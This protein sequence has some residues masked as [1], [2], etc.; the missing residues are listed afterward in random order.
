MGLV[1]PL[2]GMAIQAGAAELP[3]LGEE[4]MSLADELASG[5]YSR[6]NLM[7]YTLFQETEESTLNPDNAAE[8][9]RYQ[10]V[11]N[12]R[13][14]LNL[15][16]RNWEF[17][18][19]P[20]F[21]AIWEKWEDGPR[22]GDDH[23]SS[24]LFLTEGWVRYRPIDELTL[25]F[26]RENL[27]WGPSVILSLSNPF[28]RDNGRNNP[29][30]EVPGLDYYRAIWIP[31]EAWTVS[32]IA[33]YGPGRSD[34]IDSLTSGQPRFSDGR[35]S[36]EDEF[37]KIYAL[38]LDYTGS[39]GYASIIHS[40]RE[41]DQ[42]QTGFFAGW[43]ASDALL[44]Y[45]EGNVEHEGKSGYQ[46]GASYT[47]EIGPTVNIEYLRDNNRCDDE[48]MIECF[49]T[50]QVNS[51][52]VLYRQSYAM[53]QFTDTTSIRDLEYNVRYLRN[54]DDESQRFTGILEYDVTDHVQAYFTGN[55][56]T[57]G[58]DDEF[59]TLLRYSVFTGVSYTF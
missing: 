55:I 12:P 42:H 15:N 36:D 10:W 49:Q 23:D 26:G 45:T 52:S 5:F 8:I 39:S 3:E 53:I 20:R 41:S 2:A 4:Q 35:L 11:L 9:P 47:L 29:R 34:D 33:N 58:D 40:Y 28:T 37:E 1:F 57:G 16:F 31:S 19:K 25:S 38:K 6:I 44:L 18:L 30:V 48:A 17:A 24:E 46:V 56:F 50:G 51:R 43:N 32:A 22:D 21:E 14:D 54:L 7:A 13:A 27:Q 59:G